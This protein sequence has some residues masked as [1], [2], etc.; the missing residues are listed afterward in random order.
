MSRKWEDV[1]AGYVIKIG[2]Y[3]VPPHHAQ[4]QGVFLKQQAE[5]YTKQRAMEIVENYKGN[6]II[7]IED[8]I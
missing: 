2:N 8:A 4:C 1:Y 6:E 3:Y 7:V 5:R